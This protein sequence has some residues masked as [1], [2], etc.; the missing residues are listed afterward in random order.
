MNSAVYYVRDTPNT[1]VIS[2]HIPPN[3]RHGKFGTN[4]GK[5]GPKWDKPGIF[6]I[7]FYYILAPEPKCTKIW[8]EKV[9]DLSSLNEDQLHDTKCTKIWSE[10]V[11]YLSYLDPILTYLSE[12]STYPFV[13]LNPIPLCIQTFTP[14]WELLTTPSKSPTLGVTWLLDTDVIFDS[15]RVRLPPKCQTQDF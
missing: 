4:V 3:T 2:V 9:P 1:S 8:S 7:R 6:Q 12:T 5:I 14:L 13:D 11:Q 15:K 10:K